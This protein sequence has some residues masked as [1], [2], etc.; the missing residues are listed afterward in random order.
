MT[1]TSLSVCSRLGA[2]GQVK[3]RNDCGRRYRP[4][5]DYAVSDFDWQQPAITRLFRPA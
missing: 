5:N 3:P 1:V 4:L 2:V